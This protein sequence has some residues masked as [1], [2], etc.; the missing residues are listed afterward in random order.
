LLEGVTRSSRT[1]LPMDRGV[2]LV[3][4]GEIRPVG[5]RDARWKWSESINEALTVIFISNP[6]LLSGIPSR[7]HHP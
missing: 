6:T 5:R 7:T 4:F 2:G 1:H 3:T